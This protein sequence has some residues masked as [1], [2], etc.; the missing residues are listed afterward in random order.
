MMPKTP[1]AFN[2]TEFCLTGPVNAPVVVFIHG[3]GL[4]RDRDNAI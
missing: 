1:Q 2:G 3:L 4:C